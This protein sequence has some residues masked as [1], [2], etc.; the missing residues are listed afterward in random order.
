MD[1]SDLS[2]I[3]IKMPQKHQKENVTAVINKLFEVAGSKMK[4]EHDKEVLVG[5][6]KLVAQVEEDL[7]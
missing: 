1:K 3:L 4:D 7:Y 6:R 5:L 2:R